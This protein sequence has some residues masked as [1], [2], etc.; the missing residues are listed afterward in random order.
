MRPVLKGSCLNHAFRHV[1]SKFVKPAIKR[2]ET[3]HVRV[4]K[5]IE[6][7]HSHMLRALPGA[8]GLS[9]LQV[10]FD[11][12][13]LAVD[14]LLTNSYEE[15]ELSRGVA[16]ALASKDEVEEHYEEFAFNYWE[17]P[18]GRSGPL[19]YGSSF[20]DSLLD[21][22]PSP[23][24]NCSG[25]LLAKILFILAWPVAA[26]MHALTPDVRSPGREGWYPITLA[27][28]LAWLVVYGTAMTTALDRIGC[29]I[30]FS[31]TV[32]G[33]TLGAIGTSFPNMYASVLAAKQGEV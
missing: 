10:W 17:L 33:L 7:E 2:A 24:I 9:E 29:I 21:N 15:N 6:Y 22:S 30:Q 4:S 16:A 31:S 19:P 8:T 28:S 26:S 18:A 13:V 5:P 3:F 11:T 25:G 12:L 20:L 32:M 14:S 27:A 23:Q 1:V